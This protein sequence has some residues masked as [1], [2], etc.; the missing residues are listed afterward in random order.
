MPETLLDP[1]AWLRLAGRL[2]PLVVHFPIGLLLAAAFFETL[3]FL[4]GRRAARATD[5]GEGAAAGR[6]AVSP[7]GAACVVLGVAGAI[8]SA[9]SGWTLADHQPLGGSLADALTLHRWIGV[10]AAVAAIVVLAL[11]L[12]ASR[13]G[14]AVG[15]YRAALLLTAGLVGA[16]GHFGGSLVHGEGWVLA[17]FDPPAE[18]AIGT[19][20]VVPDGGAVVV[21]HPAVA[22]LDAACLDCHGPT[23]VRGGLRLDSRDAALAPGATAVALVPGDPATSALLTRVMLPES[24]DDFMPQGGDPLTDEQVAMLRDWIEAGAPWWVEEDVAVV[25]A[26]APIPA[27]VDEPAP[28]KDAAPAID[29]AARDAAIE[30]LLEAGAVAARLSAVDELVRVRFD[31]LGPVVS[32]ADI[33]LLEGLESTLVELDLS[34]TGVTDD[35][36]GALSRFRVL[37]ELRLGGTAVTGAGLAA[38]GDLTDLE[39]LTL[40]STAIDDAG[41]A[42]LGRLPAL[43]RVHLWGTDATSGAVRVLRAWRPDLEIVDAP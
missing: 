31:V 40:H 35:G 10:V 36:L 2:H 14:K 19:P 6:R 27:K 18:E 12:P 9:A 21:M 11:V 5:P 29:R 43:R 17:A 33:D 15:F 26:A 38:I 8:G 3:A 34:R 13:F 25:A 20:P 4:R 30:R 7:A 37:R 24:D 28:V 22:L 39:I 16:A 1:E 41:V 32:D 23:R 42:V